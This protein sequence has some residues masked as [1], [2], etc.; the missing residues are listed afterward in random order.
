MEVSLLIKEGPFL[1]A[2][3]NI[4]LYHVNMSLN[5]PF[6]TNLGTV[7]DKDFFI[8]EIIDQNGL[9]GYGESVAFTTP[10][11][12]EETFK[13]TEHIIK[14]ILIPLIKNNYPIR[15]P[16]D[17]TT[18][19]TSVRRHHMAKAAIETAVWDLYA[20]QKNEPLYQL[21]GGIRKKIDVGVS[22]GIEHDISLLLNKINTY[23]KKGYKRIKIK[24]KKGYDL[25]VLEQIRQKFPNITLMV[26]AN[27]AYSLTDI[28]HLKQ[29][30]Q[31]NLLMIE[32]PLA[33]DD[34]IDHAKLQSELNTPICLDESIHSLADVKQALAFHSCKIINVK[35]SRV[36][37]I[38]TAKKIHNLCKENAIDLWCGGMLEAGIGRAHNIALASLPGFNLPGDISASSHYWKEDIIQPE[39][40]VENGQ[41]KLSNSPGIGYDLDYEKLNFYTISKKT[42]KIS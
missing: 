13:T 40:I 11:Y 30:D 34:I 32:Q 10:W 7:Q 5:H 41:I 9:S 29:F 25:Q 26:D 39:V 21:I 28:E 35:L 15:H 4:V 8:I 23:V 24:V 27:S 42:Y 16:S 12:T 36:G 18:L 38:E 17:I 22:I 14:K 2:I 31:F 37:G 33:H 3:K 20:K 19:F 1:L 6:T